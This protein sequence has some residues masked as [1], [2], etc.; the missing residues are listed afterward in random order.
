[1][2]ELTMD[3]NN[4]ALH[5]Y[6]VDLV[7]TI[8]KK[9]VTTT[10]DDDDDQDNCVHQDND[11]TVHIVSDNS[12]SSLPPFEDHSAAMD[13][14]NMNTVRMRTRSTSR[15]GDHNGNGN[16]NDVLMAPSSPS[17]SVSSLSSSS[18]V[19]SVSLTDTESC[20]VTPIHQH[21][22]HND[23]HH[24]HHHDYHQLLRRNHQQQHH[25]R[26]H[27]QGRGHHDDRGKMRSI[28]T[29]TET[30]EITP[31]SGC[32][33]SIDRQRLLTMRLR[34][35]SPSTTPQRRRKTLHGSRTTPTRSCS[36]SWPP[37][38]L[39]LSSIKDMMLIPSMNDDDMMD[40]TVT[41]EAEEMEDHDD[42][43]RF[44][45]H[46]HRRYH[47]GGASS[48]SNRILYRRHTDTDTYINKDGMSPDGK[49]RYFR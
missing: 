7:D 45:D 49:T 25:H 14:G 38:P 5:D 33:E 11:V 34:A 44:R 4:M 1:M 22:D 43:F 31:Q 19:R 32:T 47:H 40:A 24:H 41:S 27:C 17:R 20:P 18:H 48:H 6:M 3:V 12:I 46:L 21:H 36:S 35:L 16:D 26:D 29:S 28:T 39:K 42:H 15:S 2:A 30:T 8:Q 9:T 37:S 10:A 23:Y 13:I